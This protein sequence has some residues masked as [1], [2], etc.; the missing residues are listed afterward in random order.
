MKT[1]NDREGGNTQKSPKKPYSSAQT[2]ESA[3]ET[4]VGGSHYKRLA[5]QPAE[6]IHKNGI[7]FLEGNVIKYVT[8]HREKNK[9]E[10]IRK[11]IHFLQMLLEWEYPEITGG[12]IVYDNKPIT[13]VQRT[14]RL[15]EK[16]ILRKID[17][18]SKV[19]KNQK[20]ET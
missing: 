4:Q 18:S 8:R 16:S 1:E 12:E 2:T 11:A 10:D 19:T 13:E 7:G 6:Y 14:R 17:R 3:T 15:F 9:A 20:S 5:I